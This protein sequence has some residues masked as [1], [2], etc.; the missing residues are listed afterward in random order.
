[1]NEK[2]PSDQVHTEKFEIFRNDW[3]TKKK[4]AGRFI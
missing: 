1:M 3:V 4:K 2:F